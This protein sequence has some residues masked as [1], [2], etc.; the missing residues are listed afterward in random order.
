MTRDRT[1][2][3]WMSGVDLSNTGC[4]TSGLSLPSGIGVRRL[5]GMGD[6]GLVVV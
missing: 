5:G 4:L 2:S 3:L 1:G 6:T